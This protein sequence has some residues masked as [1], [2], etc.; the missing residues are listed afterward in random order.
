MQFIPHTIAWHSLT[1]LLQMLHL[2]KVALAI[3][4]LK[5]GKYLQQAYK[6]A[7]ELN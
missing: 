7:L 2:T 3:L 5:L 4:K 1:G 6:D